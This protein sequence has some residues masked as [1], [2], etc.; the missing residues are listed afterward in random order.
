MAAQRYEIEYQQALDTISMWNL[1]KALYG[2]VQCLN[3]YVEL[4]QVAALTVKTWCPDIALVVSN[5][6]WA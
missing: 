2:C 3:A 5:C 4:L 6:V 1:Q